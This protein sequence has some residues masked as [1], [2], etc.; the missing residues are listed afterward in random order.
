MGI[1][2]VSTAIYGAVNFFLHRVL[3]VM[4]CQFSS[5]RYIQWYNEDITL[6]MVVYYDRLVSAN[7]S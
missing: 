2:S 7:P 5:V 4:T 3:G 1:R 6:Y